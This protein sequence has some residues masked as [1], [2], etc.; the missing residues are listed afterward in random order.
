MCDL[1]GI[2]TGLLSA[3][4]TPSATRSGS[5]TGE[6]ASRT[7]EGLLEGGVTGAGVHGDVKTFEWARFG[8]AKPIVID[9]KETTK[10]TTLQDEG[11]GK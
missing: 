10:E 4:K 9:C 6:D 11:R 2:S 5:G 1:G 8:W 7:C 3:R